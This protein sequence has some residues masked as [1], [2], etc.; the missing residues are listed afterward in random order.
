[1][2]PHSHMSPTNAQTS[3]P[4][5]LESM[6]QSSQQPVNS[7]DSVRTDTSRATI[8][9][10]EEMTGLQGD[11]STPAHKLFEEWLLMR[12]WPHS[13]EYLQKLTDS[14]R[15]LSDYPMQLEKDRGLV[16]P[17]DIGEGFDPNDAAQGPGSPDGST[18]AGTPSSAPGK[19]DLWGHPPH[20]ASPRAANSSAPQDNPGGLGKDGWSDFRANAVDDLLQSYVENMHKLHPFLNLPKLR[21]M[22][23]DFKERYSPNI[24]GMN[25]QSPAFHPPI[26][27][28]KR[29]RSRS[30]F[31]EHYS[32]RGAIERSLRNAIILLVL[33]LGKVCSYKENLPVPQSDKCPDPNGAWGSFNHSSKTK[34][35]FNSDSSGGGRPR[36]IDIMPGMAYYAYATDILGNQ[37]GGNTVTQAQAMILASLYINQFARVLESWSW[38]DSACRIVMILLK[39]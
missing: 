10:P 4:I 33:A 35:S 36:N 20:Q 37:Q 13:E 8:P 23:R 6:F 34:G 7:A 30:A 28:L 27:S 18:N 3:T 11:Y 12:D 14:G 31:G 16:R 5:K 39:A 21:K 1:M 25:V 24:K 15:A 38:I 9:E 17:W 2:V 29:K 26:Q 32:P 19:A 22:V